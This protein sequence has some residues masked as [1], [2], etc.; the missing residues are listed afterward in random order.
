MHL[1][2]GDRHDQYAM[3]LVH[4]RRLVFEPDHALLPRSED[5]GIDAEQVT[6]IVIVE[7]VDHH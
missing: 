1:L 5:G 2:R 6:A 7:V 3:D 4:P